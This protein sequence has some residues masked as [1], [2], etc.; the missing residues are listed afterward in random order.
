MKFTKAYVLSYDNSIELV[1]TDESERNEMALAFWQEGTYERFMYEYNRCGDMLEEEYLQGYLEI[2]DIDAKAAMW[3]DRLT[4]C[5][6]VTSESL[7][8]YDTTFCQL[9]NKEEDK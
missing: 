7:W 2:P 3:A 1:F 4:L 5:S 8:T 6:T 9:M